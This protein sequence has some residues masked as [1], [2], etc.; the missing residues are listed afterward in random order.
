[1]KPA[2][3]HTE[4]IHDYSIRLKVMRVNG[5]VV[6]SRAPERNPTISYDGNE[7]TIIPDNFQT[8]QATPNELPHPQVLAA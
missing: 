4:K 2:E 5:A 8:V 1:M 7:D 6:S 3:K